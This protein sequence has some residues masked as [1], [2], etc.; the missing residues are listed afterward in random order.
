LLV[1]M[2]QVFDYFRSR[3]GGQDFDTG[4]KKLIYAGP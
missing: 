1:E 4:D 3:T 2:A